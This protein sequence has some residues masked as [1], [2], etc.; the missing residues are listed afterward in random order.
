MSGTSNTA[1]AAKVADA[2][3][4][5]N[6]KAKKRSSHSTANCY[7]PGGGK[8]GQF[9]PN[10]SQRSRANT[11]ASSQDTLEHFVLSARV[12]ASEGVSGII[13]DDDE[14][15]SDESSNTPLTLVGKGFESFGKGKT[16][17][18]M[19]SGAS[20]TMF[21]SEEAFET[22][23]AIPPR[24]GDSAKA[25]DGSFDIV[26]EGTVAKRYLV[27][28]TEKKITYTHA[29]HTPTLNANLISVSALDRAGLTVTFSGGKGVVRKKDGTII[30]TAQCEKGMYVVD[31][32]DEPKV[33]GALA[34]SLLKA[35]P[36]E[37]WHRRLIHCSPA[38][39]TEMVK[40]DLV[41]G[42]VISEND[43]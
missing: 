35:A 5:P 29:I 13:L 23:K 38:T 4:N 20:D 36:L 11:A 39:I 19:D 37:Q 6:C 21:V 2:C 33:F 3:T 16:P 8:E 18:F 24:S 22:Y 1:L 43:L 30:L 42:L 31:E 9:P 26:G 28:G 32:I 25:V 12:P 17:T 41:N 15:E 40:G 7:W 34:S 10:F 14:V 27:N